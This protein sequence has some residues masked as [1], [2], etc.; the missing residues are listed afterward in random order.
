MKLKEEIIRT[1][2]LNRG[3]YISGQA[4]ASQLG[5]SRNAIWKVINKLKEEGYQI[6]SITNKG[7]ALADTSD[8]LSKEGIL[9][10]LPDIFH[11]LPILVYKEI[12]STNEEAKRLLFNSDNKNALIVSDR[13]SV[14]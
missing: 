1:L 6:E 12:D 5:C 13:K 2:E 11:T 4:L 10:F 3:T 8:I 9:Q 14:V 7:Y